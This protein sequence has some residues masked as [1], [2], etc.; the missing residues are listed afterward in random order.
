MATE[1]AKGVRDGMETRT[2]R[3]KDGPQKIFIVLKN[4]KKINH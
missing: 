4:L 2:V 3:L 1:I